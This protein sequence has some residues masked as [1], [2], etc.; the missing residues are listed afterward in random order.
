MIFQQ[1]K[2]TDLTPVISVEK[3]NGVLK[4]IKCEQ[5]VMTTTVYGQR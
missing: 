4:T 3:L 2:N 5:F 1:H